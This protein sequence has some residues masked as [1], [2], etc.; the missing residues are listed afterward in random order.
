MRDQNSIP[1]FVPY[2]T[3]PNAG[4]SLRELTIGKLDFLDYHPQ[5]PIPIVSFEP[6]M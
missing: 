5:L 1:S 4:V 6:T 3:Y 2:G